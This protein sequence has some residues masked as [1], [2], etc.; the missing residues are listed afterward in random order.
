M[1]TLSRQDQ[2]YIILLW[3]MSDVV[4]RQWDVS[5]KRFKVQVKSVYIFGKLAQFKLMLK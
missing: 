1:L 5:C 4:T 2:C 3:L